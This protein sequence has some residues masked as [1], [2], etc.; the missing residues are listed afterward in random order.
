MLV[1]HEDLTQLLQRGNTV[2]LLMVLRN[3]ST[4][5]F[6]LLL[7][8]DRQRAPWQLQPTDDSLEPFEG[9]RRT[10]VVHLNDPVA[11]HQ[12]RNTGVD[13]NTFL[14]PLPNTNV[15]FLIC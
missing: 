14:D 2:E 7:S 12:S 13:F 8:D 10:V 6:H 5:L 15:R 1:R 4:T 11:K 9:Q 3:L